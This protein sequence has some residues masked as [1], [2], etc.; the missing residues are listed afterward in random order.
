MNLFT[1]HVEA[2]GK[3]GAA[4]DEHTALAMQNHSAG[5]DLDR[6]VAV[7][8]FPGVDTPQHNGA[9]VPLADAVEQMHL[10]L[11]RAL[12]HAEARRSSKRLEQVVS[13][14]RRINSQT[15]SRSS[16][17][18]GSRRSQADR[19]HEGTLIHAGSAAHELAHASVASSGGEWDT[20]LG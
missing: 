7:A 14:L 5:D 20:F 9:I 13:Q 3:E 6:G 10:D 16:S 11:V 8:C 15:H 19:P 18:I 12:L 1:R 4:H 17:P 2:S